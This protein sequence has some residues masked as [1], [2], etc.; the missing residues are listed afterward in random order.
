MKVSHRISA[1]ISAITLTACA[2][3][4]GA[5]A[6]PAHAAASTAN[7]IELVTVTATRTV[8]KL[9]D[10]PATVSVLTSEV[11]EERLAQD[12]KDL[13]RFEPGVAVP[14]SPARFTAAGSATGRDGHSGFNIRG[15]EG[16]RVLTQ[17][18]GV[19]IAD[20]YSFGAQSVGRGD[21][22]DLG[23]LKSVEIV[24]GPASALYGSDGIAGAVTFL[25][26]DPADILE[27]GRN[28]AVRG[29]AAYASADNARSETV[30]AAGKADRWSSLL[31][32]TRRDG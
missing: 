13:I 21:Y 16:N 20:G 22:V 19:R 7:D 5:L 14:T 31:A 8:T 3:T 25:T 27:D 23:L 6:R 18:D 28:W 2:V 17:V 29:T 9:S 11:I 15:L 32:Y 1:S 4:L 12:I 10:A 24:R 26:K 30:I